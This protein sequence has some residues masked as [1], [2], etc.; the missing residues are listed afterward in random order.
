MISGFVF[1]TPVLAGPNDA[2][3]QTTDATGA[4][5]LPAQATECCP[6]DL[7]GNDKGIVCICN[8]IGGPNQQFG[9]VLGN[10]AYALIFPMGTLAFVAFIVGGGM[11]IFS[12]G[13]EETVKKGKDTMI[14]AIIGL[15]VV[16]ASYAILNFFFESVSPSYEPPKD[17]TTQQ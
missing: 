11:W 1:V 9:Q 13:N 10:V 5:K 15:I 4:P 14:W 12:N 8:P 3:G 7:Q 6:K 16:F 2:T 17:A